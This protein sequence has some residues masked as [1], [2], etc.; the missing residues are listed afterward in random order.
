[1]SGSR[2]VSSECGHQHGEG[3]L[4]TGTVNVSGYRAAGG[5][6]NMSHIIQAALAVPTH[7]VVFIFID[8]QTVS[9]RIDTHLMCSFLLR[10]VC[11]GDNVCESDQHWIFLTAENQVCVKSRLEMYKMLRHTPMLSHSV[12]MSF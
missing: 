1:M 9:A 11:F 4:G 10:M 2:A 12:L 8:F 3:K 6:L 7:R 5:L